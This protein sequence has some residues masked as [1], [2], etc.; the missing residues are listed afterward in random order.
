MK[1]ES[2]INHSERYISPIAQ[3][4]QSCSMDMLTGVFL[5]PLEDSEDARKRAY[6]WYSDPA[7]Y[8]KFFLLKKAPNAKFSEVEFR[9]SLEDPI[10]ATFE[11]NHHT[12]GPIGHAQAHSIDWYSKRCTYG[13]FIGDIA[14][15]AGGVGSRVHALVFALLKV[16]GFTSVRF[17]IVSGN[18]ASLRS[19]SKYNPQVIAARHPGLQSFHLDLT[20][21]QPP[22]WIEP[23]V[24]MKTL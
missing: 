22:E 18:E 14:Y 24:F 5:K 12:Y 1:Q 7:V 6:S 21:W 9:L 15:R 2:H 20:S 19:V 16:N 17:D 4:R 8:E 23:E 11:I 10:T 13:A 3:L